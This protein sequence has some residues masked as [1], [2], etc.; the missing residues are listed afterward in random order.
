MKNLLSRGSFYYILKVLQSNDFTLY[1][2]VYTASVCISF[3]RM[4]ESKPYKMFC[5]VRGRHYSGNICS[6]RHSSTTGSVCQPLIKSL[7]S[8]LWYLINGLRCPA[9]TW[10][11]DL[12]YLK[13]GTLSV[14]VDQLLQPRRGRGYL[15][16]TVF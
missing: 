16:F 5:M 7:L 6:K 10:M 9:L 3:K 1:S 8:S 4:I 13:D 14:D 11:P 12:M 15:C 2:N